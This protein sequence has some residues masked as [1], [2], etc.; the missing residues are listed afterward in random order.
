MRQD[1]VLNE[2]TTAQQQHSSFHPVIFSCLKQ[3]R[4]PLIE[5]LFFSNKEKRQQHGN[6][7]AINFKTF[8][9]WLRLLFFLVSCLPLFSPLW[10]FYICASLLLVSKWRAEWKNW[11]NF[12]VFFFDAWKEI[13]IKCLLRTLKSE[14]KVGLYYVLCLCSRLMNLNEID[15]T[16][17][18]SWLTL[19]IFPVVLSDQL[20]L[21][22]QEEKVC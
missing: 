20:L 22:N 14:W 18:R 19:T 17:W 21:A 8:S 5:K 6:S 3:L 16:N 11:R 2:H 4:C 15:K 13:S 10:C 9:P 12:R 1:V 7:L